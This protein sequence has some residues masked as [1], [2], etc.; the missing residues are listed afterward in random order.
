MLTTVSR[1]FTKRRGLALGIVTAGIGAGI[2]II[3]P[4][5]TY[6]ISAYGWRLSYIMI[7]LVVGA[8]VASE[9]RPVSDRNGN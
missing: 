3:S 4:L 7:G 5:A 6:L 2:L 8:I 1:W 9:K